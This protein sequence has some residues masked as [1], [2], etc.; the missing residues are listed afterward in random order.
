MGYI[1]E[2]NEGILLEVTDSGPV[3]DIDILCT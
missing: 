3:G 1:L 2:P